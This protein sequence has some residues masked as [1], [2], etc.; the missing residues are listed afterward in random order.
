MCGNEGQEHLLSSPGSLDE[1]VLLSQQSLRTLLI[2]WKGAFG[3][4]D[5]TQRDRIVVAI[6]EK[7]DLG[8]TFS[9]SAPQANRQLEA[10]TKPSILSFLLISARCL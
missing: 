1:G 10:G 9:A 8:A 5:L 6:E 7:I 2:D 4:L 3:E